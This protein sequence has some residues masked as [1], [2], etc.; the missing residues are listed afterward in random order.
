[1]TSAGH[2]IRP[3]SLLQCRRTAV[4]HP[5]LVIPPSAAGVPSESLS[6]KPPSPGRRGPSY[7]QR[8]AGV[9]TGETAMPRVVV[10][11]LKGLLLILPEIPAVIIQAG[12]QAAA[13]ITGQPKRVMPTHDSGHV[14]GQLTALPPDA[15]PVAI[16]Q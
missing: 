11:D 8:N 15:A 6:G 2:A 9:A 16:S 12:R 1:M 14:C 5:L 4:S 7:H 10:G 13:A 3:V